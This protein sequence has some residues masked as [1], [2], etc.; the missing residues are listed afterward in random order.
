M[1]H[2]LIDL[3]F[4]VQILRNDIIISLI[5]DVNNLNRQFLVCGYGYGY[6]YGYCIAVLVLVLVLVLVEVAVAVAV[7]VLCCVRIIIHA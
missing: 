7:A 4:V 1:L 6:G 2:E 5:E 3:K